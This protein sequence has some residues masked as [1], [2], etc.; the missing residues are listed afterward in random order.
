MELHSQRE[1]EEWRAEQQAEMNELR[2][3]TISI[4]EDLHALASKISLIDDFFKRKMLLQKLKHAYAEE[5]SPA[6]E[7]VSLLQI[8]GGT[9]N[10]ML[11]IDLNQ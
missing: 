6:K 10:S 5:H 2:A 3:E 7:G 8:A 11:I 1:Q 4:T 9:G